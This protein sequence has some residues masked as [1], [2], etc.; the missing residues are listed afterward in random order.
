MSCRGLSGW[1]QW[2]WCV[3]R[4]GALVALLASLIVMIPTVR[5]SEPPRVALVIGNSGYQQQPL[6]NPVNDAR[7]MA[8]RLRTLGFEVVERSD[9]RM[10]QIGGTLREFRSRLKPGSV[11]L[12]FYAGHGLQ[13]R[14][15]NFLPAVDAQ[16]D[17]EED[18]PNQSLAV[19]QILDL[20]A[21]AGTRLN[22]VFLDSC[23]DNPFQRG[24]RSVSRGL[25]RENVP[26][27]TLLSFATR[28]GGV[29]D[30]GS[31]RNGVYT[32]ALLK[33]M[34]STDQPI[35]RVLKDVVTIVRAETRNRQEPWVEGSIVGDFCF[36]RCGP[37]GLAASA[38]PAEREDR[39]WSDTREIGNRDA[40]EAYLAEYPKGRYAALARA[41]IARLGQAAVVAAAPAVPAVPVP[42]AT[43][44]QSAPPAAAQSP[45][46]PA[47]AGLGPP[48]TVFRDCEVCPEMVVIPGGTFLMGSPPGVGFDDERPQR[49]LTIA[50]FAMG[51]TEVTQAQW[52]AVMGTRPSHF[53]RRFLQSGDDFPVEQVSWHD[54]QEYVRRLSSMTGRR[55]R[56]PSEAEWEYAA[57][58]GSQGA[59]S[60]G[61]D[62]TQLGLHA[63]F[64][65]NS[66]GGTQPVARKQANAFGLSD[67][68][69]NV[70]EW[71]EDC[72][73]GSYTGAPSDGR[74]WTSGECGRRVL[75]GGSWDL[76]PRGMRAAYRGR[77]GTS[78]RDSYS[79]LRVARTD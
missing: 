59:Y 15:E 58:A 75:R 16:I 66:G 14:G 60:F 23:R 1:G 64:N 74:A 67:M 33:A 19:R 5:A 2:F 49:R 25:A 45:S 12:V 29:A 26:S 73:N 18:V 77:N 31:G 53:G 24:F 44:Q 41:A 54:A 21:D 10:R 76:N 32:A 11:A 40:Y 36:G 46:P 52:F 39:F 65:G 62:E 72:W 4:A 51:R 71:V 30:D 6:R 7:D 61:D 35:E 13:I 79:G 43:V 9:L 55:Y 34:S 3:Q 42:S 8:A 37:A 78:N 17:G 47:R 56:L 28:P 48:G 69:G 68:H 63:W 57:R 70:W 27:G 22:L 50:P 20:L 38:S